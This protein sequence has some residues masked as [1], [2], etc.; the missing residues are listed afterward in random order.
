M[1]NVTITVTN[2]QT[3]TAHLTS[4]PH[5][6]SGILYSVPL[7]RV[8][9]SGTDNAG[10]AITE[11]FSAIRFGVYRS[12]TVSAHMVGLSDYQTHTLTWGNIT[13]MSGNA[14]R[15][16]AG[17]FIHQGPANPLGGTFGSIGC[18]EI[19]GPGK[20]AEFNQ[21]ILRLADCTSEAEVSTNRLLSA[22]YLAATKPALTKV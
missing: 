17:F 6:P 14:W 7:Y 21:L 2:I 19:T 5:R 10:K 16:Y 20:W 9:V 1:R 12:E 13:T 8:T 15:V 22:T 18:I 4:Y 3:G 11:N